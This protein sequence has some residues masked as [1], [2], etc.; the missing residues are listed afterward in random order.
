MEHSRQ[1][2]NCLCVCTFSV[3]TQFCAQ[4]CLMVTTATC[5]RHPFLMSSKSPVF[6]K[7]ICLK[8][9][10]CVP[11]VFKG[12]WSGADVHVRLIVLLQT[13]LDAQLSEK[14][15]APPSEQSDML[16]PFAQPFASKHRHRPP[17]SI[18]IHIL[19]VYVWIV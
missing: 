5:I 14:R 7:Q 1:A 2:Y 12:L 8:I 11:V 3:T 9:R 13:L 15:N 19:C 17:Q 4:V 10:E 6:L 16:L 18:L